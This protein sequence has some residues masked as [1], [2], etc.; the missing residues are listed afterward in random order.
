MRRLEPYKR[1]KT[2]E[3]D[4]NE[5]DPRLISIARGR[6]QIVWP[7]VAGRVA[8]SRTPAYSIVGAIRAHGQEKHGTV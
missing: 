3:Q 6:S 5:T 8:A 4:G 2:A 1:G 7:A